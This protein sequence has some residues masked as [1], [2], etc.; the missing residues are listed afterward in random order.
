MAAMREIKFRVWDATQKRLLY[1]KG[2]LYVTGSDWPHVA[3]RIDYGG[4]WPTTD[5]REE[6]D[7]PSILE[8]YTGLNDKEG[9]EIYDG[10][11]VTADGYKDRPGSAGIGL[12]QWGDYGDYEYV[13]CLETWIIAGGNWYKPTPLSCVV[14]SVGVRW[15]RGVDTIRDTIRVLGNIHEN[16]ELLKTNE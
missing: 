6:G 13:E 8:Q 12:V 11:I 4:R 5:A 7:L 1:P 14:R 3:G 2:C 10:D 16:P 15:S 9:Q